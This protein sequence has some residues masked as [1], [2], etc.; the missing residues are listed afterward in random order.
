LPRPKVAILNEHPTWQVGLCEELRRRDIDFR[1]IPIQA[2]SFNLSSS[3]F[4]DID[5]A[6]NRSSPSA[7]TRNHQ[8][9]LF[10]TLELIEHLERL[11]IPVIN[12]SQ[13]YSL[14]ISKARQCQLFHRLE[15]PFPQTIVVNSAEQAVR[16]ARDLVFPL[17]LKP[18]IGGSGSGCNFFRR[19]EELTVSEAVKVL[20]ASLDHVAVL[21]EYLDPD[22]LKSYRVQMIGTTHLYTVSAHGRGANKCLSPDCVPPELY[23]PHASVPP[24]T[25]ERPS[26][27]EHKESPEVIDEV[28]R[29]AVAGGLDTCGV[30]YLISEGKRYYYDINALSIFADERQVQF[31]APVNPT[32]R[33]VDLIEQR[34]RNTN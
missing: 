16:A 9:S 28:A 12:G 18:N 25:D 10:F 19:N 24:C 23:D 26:F 11:G 21:Q 7:I 33:F 31:A 2:T 3:E 20:K 30:E 5:L 6:I 27:A 34:L 4:R 17:V 22:D 1:E 14:E 32:A 29:I 8:A 15:I 13:A